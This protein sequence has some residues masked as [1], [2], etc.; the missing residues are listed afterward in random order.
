MAAASRTVF[1]S[2]ERSCFRRVMIASAV[3][4]VS[5]RRSAAPAA[6]RHRAGYFIG[7]FRTVSAANPT[8]APTASHELPAARVKLKTPFVSLLFTPL[9]NRPLARSKQVLITAMARDMQTGTEYSAD[10]KTLLKVGGPPLLMEPVEAT[11]TLVGDKVARV[12][13][14]DFYGV[15]TARELPVKDNTFVID[16]RYETYLL[17]SYAVTSVNHGHKCGGKFGSNPGFNGGLL[18]AG[19]R[20][21]T[22]R[23]KI[24]IRTINHC[25]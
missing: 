12:R 19:L 6:R 8:A 4:S 14:V 17:R 24:C 18:S 7:H 20:C 2:S 25:R 1:S 21:R 23:V 9:D 3:A 22:G 13:A 16:G 15:P 10:G 11:I 5:A